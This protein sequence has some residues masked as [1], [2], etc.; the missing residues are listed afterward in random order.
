MCTCAHLI[1]MYGIRR[2]VIASKV[3]GKKSE[4]WVIHSRHHR[5]ITSLSD[6]K[7]STYHYY[8]KYCYALYKCNA[9]MFTFLWLHIILGTPYCQWLQ[10][11]LNIIGLV[12]SQALYHMPISNM[13]HPM[14]LLQICHTPLILCTT[15]PF[16]WY[17][18]YS[19]NQV[20]L[21]TDF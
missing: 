19:D 1:Y 10:L 3:D 13:I 15:Q 21:I 17:Q 5:L 9:T 18:K 14:G 2:N 7:R 12:L 8:Y 11:N 4:N 20:V 16:S 6:H